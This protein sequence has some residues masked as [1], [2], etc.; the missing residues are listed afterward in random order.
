M[1]MYFISSCPLSRAHLPLRRSWTAVMDTAHEETSVGGDSPF[2]GS[3]HGRPASQPSSPRSSD[4]DLAND[5]TGSATHWGTDPLSHGRSG[6]RPYQQ[7]DRTPSL[8]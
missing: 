3:E 6:A 2:L 4:A 1:S 8:R 5:V 7:P